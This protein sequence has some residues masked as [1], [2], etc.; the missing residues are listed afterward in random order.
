MFH[1]FFAENRAVYEIMWKNVVESERPQ[2]TIW[3]MRISRKVPKATHTH[4][5]SDCVIRL[6]ERTSM[7]RYTY[8][9]SVAFT[10]VNLPNCRHRYEFLAVIGCFLSTSRPARPFGCPVESVWP[11]VRFVK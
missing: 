8:M 11:A 3:R 6:H 9:V 4:T 2:M 10:V 5:H 1:N 7:L